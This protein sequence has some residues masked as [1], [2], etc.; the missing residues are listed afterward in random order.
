MT[1]EPTVRPES[2]LMCET[3][4]TSEGATVGWMSTCEPSVLPFR[5]TS[6]IATTVPS[7]GE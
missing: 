1:A 3:E 7:T 2:T 6:S 4:M 5:T